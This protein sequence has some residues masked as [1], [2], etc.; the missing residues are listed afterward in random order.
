MVQ[1]AKTEYS[2]SEEQTFEDWIY[3]NFGSGIAKHFM[4]SYNEK[5]WTVHPK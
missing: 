2:N 1:T 4:I 5:L 3:K